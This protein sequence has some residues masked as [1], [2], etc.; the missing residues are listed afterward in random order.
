MLL[1]T[2]R[3][4]SDK[5]SY[6]DDEPTLNVKIVRQLI[7]ENDVSL[8]SSC[9]VGYSVKL[10][11]DLPLGFSAHIWAL[12]IQIYALFCKAMVAV[13]FAGFCHLGQPTID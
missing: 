1:E 7:A 4:L 13:D 3:N 12:G 6:N 8:R 10:W 5:V 9:V 11:T 2:T